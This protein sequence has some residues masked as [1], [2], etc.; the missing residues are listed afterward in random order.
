MLK[1]TNLVYFNTFGVIFFWGGKL[2]EENIFLENAPMPPPPVPPLYARLKFCFNNRLNHLKVI[3]FVNK[4]KNFCWFRT[5][6]LQQKSACQLD[7][8][9]SL[10][11]KNGD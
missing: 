1:L 5:V 10:F 9:E 6:G 3:G 11:M 2:G 4:V 8:I 7:Q